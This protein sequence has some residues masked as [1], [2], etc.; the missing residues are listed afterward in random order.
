MPVV[1]HNL[2]RFNSFFLLKGL[3]SGV[4]KTMD[5]KIGGK[6]P[7]D[8]NFTSIGNQVQFIDTVKYFQQSL[9]GLANDLINKGKSAI[10]RECERFLRTDS[11]FLLSM[12]EEK[13]GLLNYLL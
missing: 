5:V 2:F 12:Q 6:D 10:S 3:W 7:T 9:S 1:I 4:W 11:Q 13:Q 8:I